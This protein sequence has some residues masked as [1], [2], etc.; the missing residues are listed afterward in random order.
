V[1]SSEFVRRLKERAADLGLPQIGIAPIG[2]SDHADFLR[3][4]LAAG[5]AATMSWMHRTAHDSVDLRRRFAWARS[6]V[7]VAVPYL[8]YRGDRHAQQGLLPHVARYA[9]GRDYHAVLGE[10]LE[11]L[12]G[13]IQEE[14]PGT[15]TRIYVDTGPVLEREL[16]A[17]AGLGWFGKNTNL[18][19][20]RGDSWTLLGQILT[21]LD[22]PQDSPAA[23]RC[24]T[25]TACL[26]A[27]PT[28]AIP[29]P[30]LVDSNRCISYLTIEL[31]G[32]VPREQRATIDDW[33]LGCDICQEV[34]P[35]NRKVVPDAEAAFRPGRH[36]EQQELAGLIGMSES[37]FRQRFEDTPFERPRRRGV[38]RNA[39]IVAANTGSDAAASA[40]A[41]RLD[42][43]DPVIRGTAAWVQGRVGGATGR[44]ALERARAT[45]M[46]PVVQVEIEAALDDIAS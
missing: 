29:E 28:G 6:A 12:N 21:S 39:L 13:V 45:E 11:R 5:H 20:P 27:C 26:D 10:R 32:N 30:Y 4:W 7:V 44:A 19:G 23:D 1:N 40:A 14:A 25:C 38:V 37:D 43:P 33:I 8:S 36:L 22:L 9:V 31:R 24:G 35:W 17:R 16:A 18:I 3:R 15:Q 34:C 2:P 46:D 41:E 42:D